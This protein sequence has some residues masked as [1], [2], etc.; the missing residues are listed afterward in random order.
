VDKQD[1]LLLRSIQQD[2]SLSTGELAEKVG[3]SKSACWRRLQKLTAD[4]VIKKQVA[5]LDAQK[6]NLPLTVY[7][8]I[9][10]NEHNDNWASQFQ[11][12]TKNI[13]GI[14]EVHRMSGDLD[15]L[16]KAVVEDMQGYDKLYKQ[17]IKAELF[18]VSS[19]FVMET[20]K[21]TTELPLHSNIN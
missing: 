9:R 14:L 12:V 18:D 19:S 4:G 13:S 1:L 16:L 2:S 20:M 3:M 11:E 8:S 10:T 21:Q 17:L 5:I 6:L 15:Y 7:I